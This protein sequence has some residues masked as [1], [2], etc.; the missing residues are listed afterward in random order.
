MTSNNASGGTGGPGAASNG[1]GISLGVAQPGGDGSAPNGSAGL[2]DNDECGSGGSGG[3]GASADGATSSP[4]QGGTLFVGGGDSPGYTVLLGGW[5]GGG[6]GPR[7]G[8]VA[9]RLGTG[10][11]GGGALYIG[12]EGTIT[13]S[14]GVTISAKGGAG[15]QGKITSGGGGGGGGGTIDLV[16]ASAFNNQGIIDVRGGEGGTYETGVSP[17]GGFGGAGGPGIIRLD[18]AGN[19]TEYTGRQDFSGGGTTG[20]GGGTTGGE[21][22]SSAGPLNSNISCGTIA[23]KN[24]TMQNIYLIC[25]GLI[26][27]FGITWVIRA[28]LKFLSH[29]ERK[30]D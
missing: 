3:A 12:A 27:A 25:L 28:P 7:P 17:D 10:G 2:D 11:G 24:K 22:T 16:T 1:G 23:S 26:L 13:I 4:C 18:L 14:S 5:G 20:G 15:G 6:G 19:V 8:G 29:P 30:S 9:Q 21:V